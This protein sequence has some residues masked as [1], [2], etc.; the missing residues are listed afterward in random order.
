MNEGPQT[1]RLS[2]LVFDDQRMLW[3]TIGELL[4]RGLDGD[5]I[6]LVGFQDSLAALSL[7]DEAEASVNADLSGFVR[8]IQVPIKTDGRT[9]LV[10]RCGT[11]PPGSRAPCTIETDF[12]WMDH[13]LSAKL[14]THARLGAVLLFVRARNSEQHA[15]VGRIL[16]RHGRHS[17]QTH[18][19]TARSDI[20]KGSSPPIL[21][22]GR[23]EQS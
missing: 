1:V 9:N 14:I 3:R 8:P 20:A 13:Q 19:Y 16:L 5:Q 15:V 6:C 11:P 4:H 10:G 12:S 21:K 23:S 2:I 18:E 22:P 17:L 7:P